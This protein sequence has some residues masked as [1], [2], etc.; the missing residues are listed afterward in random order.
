MRL[1]ADPS[2]VTKDALDKIASGLSMQVY[3]YD[4]GGVRTRGKYAGKAMHKFVIRPND[5][6]GAKPQDQRFRLIRDNPY[7]TSGNGR[8]AAWAIC[9]HGHWFFIREVMRL[10]PNAIFKTGV[11]IWDG[12]DDFLV[13]AEGSGMRDI[14]SPMSPLFYNK[15]CNCVKRGD[16]ILPI[17]SGHPATRTP[18]FP[19][20]DL[21]VN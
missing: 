20:A 7:A 19:P 2:L 11:D 9:W 16:N 4:F 21:Y 8:R 14:G 6:S 1:Y 12:L 17:E 10:D 5:M 3:D 13:R 18:D 15:A